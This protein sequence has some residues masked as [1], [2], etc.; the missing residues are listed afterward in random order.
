MRTGLCSPD[1]VDEAT[2]F[3]GAILD[4]STKKWQVAEVAPGGDSA[5]VIV[6]DLRLKKSVDL[7][8]FV[9]EL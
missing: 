4:E 9:Q 7:A 1:G 5:I 8:A 2:T 6:F 3:A